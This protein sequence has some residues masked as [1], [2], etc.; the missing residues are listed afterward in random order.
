MR[1]NDTTDRP[2]E[3]TAAGDAE[4]P[5]ELSTSKKLLFAAVMVA[6]LLGGGIVVAELGVRLV[7]PQQLCVDQPGLY[8]PDEAIGWRRNAN[9]DF[10]VNSGERDVQL[11]TDAHGHRISCDKPKPACE[12]RVLV[13]GD[14]FVEAKAVP[15]D[16]TVWARLEAATGACL[17][18][19]GVGGWGMAQYRRVIEEHLQDGKLP[20]DVVLLNF[21]A[22]NDFHDSFTKVPSPRA[23]QSKPLRLFPAGLSAAALFDWAYPINQIIESHSHA[24]VLLRATIRAARKQP[25]KYHVYNRRKT[26]DGHVDK[27]IDAAVAL[28]TWTRG[29]GAEVVFTLVPT[30]A[31]VRDPEAKALKAAHPADA[32]VLDVSWAPDRLAE[33]MKTVEEAA[34]VDLGAFLRGRDIDPAWWGTRDSHFS[35]KGHAMWFEAVRPA[36]AAALKR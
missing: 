26:S 22:G 15:W 29:L 16:D 2:V 5:L 1:H 18:V 7:A 23:V 6:V 8:S 21:Y 31:G 12:Q 25:V 33:R 20:Y 30:E 19:A 11:C 10:V 24:Y 27:A 36:L 34:F 9:L 14:S 17:D 35:P 32:D 4:P 3:T 28:T 13:V